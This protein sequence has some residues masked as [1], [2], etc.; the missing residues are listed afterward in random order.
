MVLDKVLDDMLAREAFKRRLVESIVHLTIDPTLLVTLLADYADPP[1]M[2][3]DHTHS[4]RVT[5]AQ[6]IAGH[7]PADERDE[8]VKYDPQPEWRPSSGNR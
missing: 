7:V 3:I 5:L 4:G 1:A 8:D 6:I 2:A